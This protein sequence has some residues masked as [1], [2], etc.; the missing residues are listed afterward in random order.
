MNINLLNLLYR[1][2][3]IVLL[4]AVVSVAHAEVGP[5]DLEGKDKAM[6]DRFRDLFQ[7]GTDQA[8]FNFAKDYEKDLK[9][10]GYMMLYYKL[11]N[12]EGFFALR[13]NKIYRAM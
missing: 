7:N 12:N 11:L 4:T 10:K 9:S 8:F 2:L 1:F 6:F 13:H 3:T 5:A